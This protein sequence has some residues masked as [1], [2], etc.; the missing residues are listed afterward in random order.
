MRV[1][2]ICEQIS[3]NF[4]LVGANEKADLVA[5]CGLE[6]AVIGIRAKGKVEAFLRHGWMPVRVHNLSS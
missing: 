4:E 5:R 3:I 6:Q 1:N 2:T